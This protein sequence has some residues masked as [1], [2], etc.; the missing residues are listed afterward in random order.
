VAGR[1]ADRHTRPDRGSYAQHHLAKASTSFAFNGPQVTWITVSGPDQGIANVFVDNTLVRTVDHYAAARTYNVR[2]TFSGLSTGNHVLR[3]E[4]TGEK[5]AAATDEFVAV[6]AMQVGDTMVDPTAPVTYRWQSDS[7]FDSTLGF[8][9]SDLGPAGAAAAA[10]TATFTFR[11]PAVVWHTVTGPSMGWARV[12]VDGVNQGT[13]TTTTRS[14]GSSIEPSAGSR[15]PCTHW[16]SPRWAQAA[17]VERNLRRGQGLDRQV[18]ARAR[19]GRAGTSPPTGLLG[20]DRRRGPWHSNCVHRRRSHFPFVG[21]QSSGQKL[22]RSIDRASGA[23]AGLSACP[24]EVAGVATDQWHGRD[25]GNLV[26][27]ECP[28]QVSNLRPTA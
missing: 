21:C 22:V 16:S 25:V 7:A 28:E 23:V 19:A 3:I 13:S 11:G 24:V 2:E 8:V 18:T 12:T 20:I 9:R 15:T 4:P 27:A 6:D 5:N 17:G 1:Q 14:A 26:A 10:T